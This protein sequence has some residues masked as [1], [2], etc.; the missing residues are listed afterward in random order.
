[1]EN[2]TY[3][4]HKLRKGHGICPNYLVGYHNNISPLEGKNV[5]A[6]FFYT[7]G[8]FSEVA[9]L[10]S[11]TYLSCCRNYFKLGEGGVGEGIFLLEWEVSGAA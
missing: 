2:R 9:F 6:F 8:C 5:S 1:M 11:P 3:L 10:P 4:G 7:I